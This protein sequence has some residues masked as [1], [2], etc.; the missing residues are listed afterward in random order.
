MIH[1]DA[2]QN[3]IAGDDESADLLPVSSQS[4]VSSAFRKVWVRVGG[5]RTVEKHATA[6]SKSREGSFASGLNLKDNFSASQLRRSDTASAYHPDATAQ[7]SL[8]ERAVTARA[9]MKSWCELRGM[10][11]MAFVTIPLPEPL[12]ELQVRARLFV[13]T[14]ESP[15]RA[16]RR[17]VQGFHAAVARD[18]GAHTG[19]TNGENGG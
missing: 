15:L 18:F 5:G 2:F 7:Q 10:D 4:I 11:P 16:F 19:Y 8:L 13:C 3:M 1:R 14:L 17:S 12:Q 6:I 9:T